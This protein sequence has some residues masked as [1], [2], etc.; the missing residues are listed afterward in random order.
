MS[1]T[2]DPI[3]YKDAG[4]DVQAGEDFVERIR[5]AVDSTRN[6]R[7][8]GAVGGFGGLF[9]PDLAGFEEPVLVSSADGVGTKLKL[10]FATGLH[11]SVGGDLVRHCAN[12]IAVL[13]A[14][15]LYF[16]DYL[17]TGRLAPEVLAKLVEGMAAA[18][19]AEGMALLGGETAEMPGF[20]ADG[21]YDCAGFIV[22]IVDRRNLLDGT[23]IR[24]GDRLIGFA[25]T[26]LHT[27]GYSLARRIVDELD[28]VDLGSSPPELGGPT[29]GDALMAPHVSYAS[30]IAALLADPAVD[31]K[32]LA[33][34]TG[35]GI[36]GNLK[37]ILP[38]DVDARV[39]PDTWKEPPVFGFLRTG[40]RVPE[41]DMRSAFNLGV[42]L[43]A[44]VDG[45]TDLGFPI[46]EIGAGSGRV[47]WK[48]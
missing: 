30:E 12:D 4:V 40:G 34:I 1:E 24:P 39:Q 13:G 22:G 14:R 21:E 45:Q 27:N 25:S 20:Y 2:K 42:G 41:D 18:C 35:G 43:I 31:V 44:V 32:G 7:V 28:G 23:T 6:P 29:V 8:L 36:G 19:A 47:T 10:A 9:A 38:A 16:L 11:E 48:D 5:T 3:L 15:P 17:A 33:H 26:G 46:G 37:R